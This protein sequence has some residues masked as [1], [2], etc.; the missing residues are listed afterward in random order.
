[1]LKVDLQT[2]V[3][4]LILAGALAYLVHRAWRRINAFVS[5]GKP[6][7]TSCGG[8][9]MSDTCFKPALG[10]GRGRK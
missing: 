2:L 7:E 5:N 6:C 3:L 1:M 4:V 8:C 9:V 10:E